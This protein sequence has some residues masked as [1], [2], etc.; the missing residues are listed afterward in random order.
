MTKD[1]IVGWH[2]QLNGHEFEQGLEESE[3]QRCL[4]CWNP[5]GHKQPDTTEQLNN[6]VYIQV[7]YSA[8]KKK[9]I[10]YLQQLKWKLK[11]LC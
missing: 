4:A 7:Y 3:G 6:E 11:T 10:F 1:D 9:V 8:M 5:R 2:H